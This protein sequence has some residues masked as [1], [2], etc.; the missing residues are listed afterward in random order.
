MESFLNSFA[1]ATNK[2]NVTNYK[3]EIIGVD[4]YQMQTNILVYTTMDDNNNGKLHVS[5]SADGTKI[6]SD[7]SKQAPS[8][9]IDVLF[10]DGAPLIYTNFQTGL[11]FSHYN[12]TFEWCENKMQTLTF[13]GRIKSRIHVQDDEKQQKMLWQ[14]M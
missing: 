5:K 1:K 12:D 10:N 3:C 4:K 2:K 11:E 13:W 9:L 8:W 14:H 7:L 6:C